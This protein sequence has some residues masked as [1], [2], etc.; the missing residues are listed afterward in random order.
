MPWLHTQ[1]RDPRT[2]HPNT[3]VLYIPPADE[4]VRA[5]LKVHGVEGGHDADVDKVDER[6][7]KHVDAGPKGGAAG[8]R[9]RVGR[10]DD[11]GRLGPS[12]VLPVVGQQG[13][14]VAAGRKIDLV[15]CALTYI[16]EQ[17]V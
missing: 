15:P 16:H 4:D 12:P 14:V 9:A 8:T 5:L 1:A 6:A 2:Q 11:R 10:D 17:R 13:W 3:T 7:L